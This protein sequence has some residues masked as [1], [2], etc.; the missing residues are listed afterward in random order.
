[1][2]SD[3][4]DVAEHRAITGMGLGKRP[5]GKGTAT[6]RIV[7]TPVSTKGFGRRLSGENS[8][9]SS[10]HRPKTIHTSNRY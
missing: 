2:A 9:L 8:R 4:L 6:P 7:H 1:M 10:P 5:S 3:P